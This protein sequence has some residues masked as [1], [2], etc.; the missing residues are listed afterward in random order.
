MNCAS[1]GRP[2]TGDETGL[3]RKLINRGTTVC[4]CL[5]CLAGMFHTEVPRLL[6]LIEQFRNAGCTLFPENGSK[7]EDEIMLHTKTFL[8]TN[9]DGIEAEG[10][11]RLARM[12]L[13]FGNVW[14]VA[15][16]G[17]RSAASHSITLRESIDLYPY[18]FPAEGVRAFTC[19]GTP[20]DCAR[21]GILHLM[22]VRPD[23]VL[24]GINFGYNMATD[25]QYSG[26]VGA[27]FEAERFGI[28]AIAFSE[29]ISD[30]HRLT[31]QKLPEV[32]GMLIDRKLPTGQIY[33]VNFPQ[34]APEECRGILENRTVSRK[35]IFQDR[36]KEVEKLPNGGIRV[37]VNGIYNEESED[38]TDFH[39]LMDRYISISTIQ[40]IC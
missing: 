38:G 32:L 36:Y 3:S 2:L 31:D 29:G 30:D 22:P 9:D 39:A 5:P 27:A 28:P 14:V 34:C 17:Q 11:V 25:I 16:E 6:E 24:S 20:A 13:A 8:I 15:P 35:G 26:T 33:N 19:S 37:H 12:A 21:I 18:R 23:L 7:G 1:C 40:N 10:L 4:Y